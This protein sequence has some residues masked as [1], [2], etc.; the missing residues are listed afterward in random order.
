MACVAIGKENPFRTQKR[1]WGRRRS[2]ARIWEVL[3]PL[4]RCHDSYILPARMFW[5]DF[6]MMGY[7]SD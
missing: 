6:I 2:F 3:E 1:L 5:R 7:F 4:D